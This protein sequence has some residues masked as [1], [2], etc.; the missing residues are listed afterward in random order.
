MVKPRKQIVGSKK[1]H[2]LISQLQERER[3]LLA[4][5]RS[6]DTLNAQIL[7]A[8]PFTIFL[9]DS[10]GRVK[11]ANKHASEYLGVTIE[12][13]AGRTKYDLFSPLVGDQI[14][15]DDQEVWRTNTL[16]TKE[17][18]IDYKGKS[19]YVFTGKKIIHAEEES[20]SHE[21]LLL[22]Y[23]INITARVQA[24]Q[25][26]RASE[27][28]FRM[29]VEQA[30]DSFFL[31]DRKG[32]IIDVNTQACRILGYTREH[33]LSMH[34]E[35]IFAL[36]ADERQKV[37]NKASHGQ[38]ANFEDQMILDNG[39]RIPVDINLGLIRMGDEEMFLALVRDITDRKKE[40]EEDKRQTQQLML[41]SEKLSVV[42]QL[43]AGI[44]HEIR[45][46]LTVVKGFL[47]LME[48]EWD[49]NPYQ[50]PYQKPYYFQ[51]LSSEIDRMELI[52]N[53]L[54]ILS[55]PQAQEYYDKN[56]RVVLEQVI[57][58]IEPQAHLQN[59][60][61]I[62]NFYADGPV[63]IRCDENQMKQ[64]FINFIKNGIESMEDG[65]E[66]LIYVAKKIDDHRD[67]I[68]ITI[69]DHGCGISEDQLKKLGEPFYS[70]KE[71]GTGLGFM[72]SKKI[73]ESHDGTLKVTS[74]VNEGTTIELFLPENP[75]EPAS[76]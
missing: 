28:K 31:V 72:V 52:V 69:I 36:P 51:V 19:S 25:Q 59:V 29:L 34:F 57:A 50:N 54:L 65:G 45:N 4:Q 41:N 68:G 73:I 1:Q 7:D 63:F 62:V 48:R 9:E 21:S 13:M 37:I 61:V 15:Q 40:A 58:L 33:L 74:K 39:T 71:R 35:M 47:K 67:G 44:A 22:G 24:E 38:T 42:G 12:Q 66:I 2:L 64:I 20:K 3:E 75:S 70:T 10:E 27:E 17:E 60:E 23:S 18:V 5:L 46:P 76:Q 11:F 26:L 16:I 8:L 55:K 43:A 6:K 49:Q 14:K 32:R 30:A 53:E 56:L